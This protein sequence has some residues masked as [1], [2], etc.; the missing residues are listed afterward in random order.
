MI[1]PADLSVPGDPGGELSFVDQLLQQS[2]QQGWRYRVQWY[3]SLLGKLSSV[4]TLIEK[5]KKAGC[6]H[7]AVTE[8]VQGNRTRRWGLAWSYLPLIP[9]ET[10]SRGT[11]AIGRAL[12]PPKTEVILDTSAIK[13][14]SGVTI[15]EVTEKL[16]KNLKAL[17]NQGLTWS[18]D[19]TGSTGIGK[20][21]GNV[22]GR[23]ARRA[24]KF[25]EVKEHIPRPEVP[26]NRVGREPLSSAPRTLTAEE[27]VDVFVFRLRVR[28][29]ARYPLS[30]EFATDS[31]PQKGKF[32]EPERSYKEAQGIVVTIHIRWLHGQ[33]AVV[34]ESFC[35]MMRRSLT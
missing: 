19:P 5:I 27:N 7:Y 18:W 28:A 13:G 4:S 31:T 30:P 25:K 11:T 9:S 2:S 16:D 23:K 6:S 35:E 22:W 32:L 21:P 17:R 29:S 10:A 15:S 1:F 8:F 14:D 24:R 34:F 33:D 26:G 20:S 3:T 12:L